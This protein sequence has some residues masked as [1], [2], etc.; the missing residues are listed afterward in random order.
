M[1]LVVNMSLC[2]P[3]SFNTNIIYPPWTDMDICQHHFLNI[4][5]FYAVTDIYLEIRHFKDEAYLLQK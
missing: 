5:F 2:A 4:I 3:V 1:D